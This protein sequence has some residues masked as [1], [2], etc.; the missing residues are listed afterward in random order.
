MQ[1]SGSANFPVVP[2]Q[3]QRPDIADRLQR[4][5]QREGARTEDQVRDERL[6]SQAISPSLEQPSIERIESPRRSE[7]ADARRQ[8]EDEDLSLNA[9][10]ALQAFAANSPTPEQQLGVELAGVDTFA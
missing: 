3:N 10:R 8:A 7:S 4:E 6:Q 1:I 2:A 5:V 9:R